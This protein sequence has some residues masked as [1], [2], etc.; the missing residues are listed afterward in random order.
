MAAPAARSGWGDPESGISVGYCTNGF[1]GDLL[2]GRRIT[3]ISALRELQGIGSEP[4]GLAS[5]YRDTQCGAA[6][7]I[8][9]IAMSGA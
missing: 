1:V 5:A 2:Q 7:M 6:R 4:T 3:A 9:A 8:F